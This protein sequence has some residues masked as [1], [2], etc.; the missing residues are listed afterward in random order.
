MRENGWL[1]ISRAE[2]NVDAVFVYVG[3]DHNLPDRINAVDVSDCQYEYQR[4]AKVLAELDD[5]PAKIVGGTGVMESIDVFGTFTLSTDC[6]EKLPSFGGARVDIVA[7]A[8]QIEGEISDGGLGTQAT[9][10]KAWEYIRESLP[11]VG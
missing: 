8:I 7:Y 11:F 5:I 2:N 3:K 6:S 9:Y 10:L 1:E 4:T